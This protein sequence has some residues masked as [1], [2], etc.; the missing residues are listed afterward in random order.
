MEFGIH[1]ELTLYA[2]GLGVL[3]GDFM[4]ACHDL[5]VPVI[6]IGLLWDEGYTRQVIGRDGQPRHRAAPTRRDNLERVDVELRVEIAGER[7]PLSAYRVRNYPTAPLYVLEP[8]QTGHAEW[9]RRLY[10]GGVEERVVQEMLL[11]IGGVRLLRAL[12]H[13]VDVYHFN[14]GHAVFAAHELIRQQ[15]YS[16]QTFDEAVATIKNSVVFTTHTPVPAGNEQHDT[17]LLLRMGANNGLDREQLDR[18]GGSPYSMTA[19]GLRM[20]RAANAVAQLHGETARG[21]WKEIPDAAPIVG[22]T[23]GVHVGTWQDGRT[24]AATVADKTIEQR[25]S[26]LW[27]AHQHMKSELIAEIHRLCGV[28]LRSDRIMVGF[29]RRAATYKRAPLIFDQ[30]ERLEPMLE[31]SRLQLVF[32]GKAHPHDHQGKSLVARLVHEAR[33]RPEQVVFLP[34]YDMRLGALMTRGCDVWLNNPRRPMEASGTSG[35]K[36]AMNGVLNLS[37]LDGWWPEGCVHGETG[38]QIGP[39]ETTDDPQEVVD[40]RDRTALYDVLTNEVLPRYYDDREAWV[41]M[42]LASIKMSQWRFSSA[43][44]VED[45]YR[46]LYTPPAD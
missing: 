18:L 40:A 23:N 42:M 27:D 41:D 25:R 7:I 3:A 22:I 31:D 9:T 34:D 6:G 38:W 32:A 20:S 4:K 5:H 12:K 8:T 30:P 39:G 17:D 28:T 14:E 33:R 43:R 44:M 10:G 46:L 1:H 36:A 16:G 13:E 19:A 15:R 29:A 24:R 26:E 2:G 11:G 35:M 21:M 37:V 45:Y